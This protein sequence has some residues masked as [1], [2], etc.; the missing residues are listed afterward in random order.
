MTKD[1]NFRLKLNFLYDLKNGFAARES[2]NS[3]SKNDFSKKKA[4]TV[5]PLY[6]NDILYCA[7]QKRSTF[8]Y[9][10]KES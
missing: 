6:K 4:L 3:S 2:G 5:F 9:E 7:I 8:I 10:S 1:G